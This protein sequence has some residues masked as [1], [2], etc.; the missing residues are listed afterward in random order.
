[1]YR[2]PIASKSGGKDLRL[3]TYCGRVARTASG[4]RAPFRHNI[5]F[6]SAAPN[7]ESSGSGGNINFYI[8]SSTA[9]VINISLDILNDIVNVCGFFFLFFFT[10]HTL[11]SPVVS[12]T[13]IFLLRLYRGEFVSRQPKR[14]HPA[15]LFVMRD[16]SSRCGKR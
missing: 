1:M 14:I 5:I 8:P 6:L 9:G 10:I 3:A 2:V 4:S 13:A 7:C 16:L 11:R 15:C 12:N